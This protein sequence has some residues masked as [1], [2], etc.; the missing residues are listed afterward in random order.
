MTYQMPV[1]A[2]LSDVVS[3]VRCG[4]SPGDRRRDSLP[5]PGRGE[6]H[7]QRAVSAKPLAIVTKQVYLVFQARVIPTGLSRTPGRV[8]NRARSIPVL[9]FVNLRKSEAEP[10]QPVLLVDRPGADKAEPLP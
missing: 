9:R 1:L 10:E 5:G 8:A 6:Q 7:A 4:T 3:M 2:P